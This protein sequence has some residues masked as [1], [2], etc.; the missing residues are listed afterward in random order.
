MHV[1]PHFLNAS[2]IPG[3]DYSKQKYVAMCEKVFYVAQAVKK[4]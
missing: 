1:P 2:Y 3:Q 4:F